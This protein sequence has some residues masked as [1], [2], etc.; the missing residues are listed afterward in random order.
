MFIIPDGAGFVREKW[1]VVINLEEAR[2]RGLLGSNVLVA[3][4]NNLTDI[5]DLFLQ[6]ARPAGCLL[7]S[8]HGKT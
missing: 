8:A 6:L 7:L 4:L 3:L 1:K 5:S 2:V